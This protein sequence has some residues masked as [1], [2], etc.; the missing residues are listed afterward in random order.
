MI[1]VICVL[2]GHNSKTSVFICVH[3]WTNNRPAR[4]DERER[5]A[6]QVVPGH[7][8]KKATPEGWLLTSHLKLIPACRC[9]VTFWGS[10]PCQSWPFP[11]FAS[12]RQTRQ[13][14]FPSSRPFFR[15]EPGASSPRP[16]LPLPAS[17]LPL[18]RR[19][20]LVFFFELLPRYHAS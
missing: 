11:S 4:D 20:A 15:A 16:L 9:S 19:F 6:A 14:L 17:A 1:R 12:V 18:L 8:N 3:L 2:C 10:S 13:S 7:N 5:C